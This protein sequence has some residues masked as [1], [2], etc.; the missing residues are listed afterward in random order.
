MN[1]RELGGIID[2]GT[3][4]VGCDSVATTDSEDDKQSVEDAESVDMNDTSVEVRKQVNHKAVENT[5]TRQR[6]EVQCVSSSPAGSSAMSNSLALESVFVGTL[7]EDHPTTKQKPL[8][9]KSRKAV[10]HETCTMY[11]PCDLYYYIILVLEAEEKPT[12]SKDKAKVRVMQGIYG[13]DSVPASYD[14]SY[15]YRQWEEVFGQRAK[16]ILKC[17]KILKKGV[18]G[19]TSICNIFT[20]ICM[21]AYSIYHH[22]KEEVSTKRWCTKL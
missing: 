19:R 10:V 16:H 7:S 18:Q 1:D 21:L 3:E 5:R 12:R 15:L 14:R 13:C 6:K 11:V 17:K 2:D 4:D 9:E 22:R 8:S 20:I